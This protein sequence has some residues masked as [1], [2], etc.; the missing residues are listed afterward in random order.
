MKRDMDL[1]RALMI[2]LSN[3]EHGYVDPD[4]VKLDGYTED[5]I[6]HHYYLLWKA[7]LIEAADSSAMD[8]SSPTAIPLSVTWAGHEFVA[9]A[10]DSGIW[11]KAKEKVL[12]PAGGVAFT[13][14]LEWLKEESMKK[15]GLKP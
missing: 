2:S 15:L 8:S 5:Q 14:L 6:D 9:A 1:C 12:A 11:A 7:G 10:S 3:Q 4:E 13:V